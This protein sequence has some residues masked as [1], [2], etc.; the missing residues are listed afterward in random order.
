MV[1]KTEQAFS[2][3]EVKTFEFTACRRMGTLNNV[4]YI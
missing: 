1:L 4:E 3:G 2:K